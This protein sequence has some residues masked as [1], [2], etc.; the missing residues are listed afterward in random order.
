MYISTENSN[1]SQFAKS[2]KL[3]ATLEAIARF[4]GWPPDIRRAAIRLYCG[5]V[6]IPPCE[7]WDLAAT[8][9]ESQGGAAN[10]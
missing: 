10:A 9:L 2:A 7:F 3:T 4:S 5:E 1:R 8:Y 6:G